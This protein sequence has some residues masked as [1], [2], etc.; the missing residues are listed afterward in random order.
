MFM[1]CIF[2]SEK[3]IQEIIIFI[4]INMVWLTLELVSSLK[5]LHRDLYL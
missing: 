1:V 5:I 2:P 4:G 3:T